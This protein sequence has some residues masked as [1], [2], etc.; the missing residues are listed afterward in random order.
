MRIKNK[1]IR[2]RRHRKETVLHAAKKAKTLKA[3][4]VELAGAESSEIELGAPATIPAKKTAAK[5]SA[6]KAEGTAKKAPKAKKEEAETAAP[7]A[8]PATEA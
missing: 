7:E 6:P 3:L 5:K 1:E 2:R 8:A 4:N